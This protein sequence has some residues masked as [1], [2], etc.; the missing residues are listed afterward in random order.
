MRWSQRTS[1]SSSGSRIS[2]G[3][4]NTNDTPAGVS[5][6]VVTVLLVIFLDWVNVSVQNPVRS[7]LIISLSQI[8]LVDVFY[9]TNGTRGIAAAGA[10]AVLFLVGWVAVGMVYGM[11]S[12]GSAPAAAGGGEY[13][14]LLLNPAAKCLRASRRHVRRASALIREK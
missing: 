7:G 10:R 3:T 6:A 8:L 14:G 4:I 2:S 13:S 11:M 12:G 9:V 1:S 5:L